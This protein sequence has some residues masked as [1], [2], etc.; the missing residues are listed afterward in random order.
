MGHPD[1]VA[2]LLTAGADRTLTDS[3]GKTALD[4]AQEKNDKRVL[5]ALGAAPR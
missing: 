2:Y 1:V 5:A 4:I 3:D